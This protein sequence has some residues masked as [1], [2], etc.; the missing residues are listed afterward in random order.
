MQLELLSCTTAQL[1]A[2]PPTGD[3]LKRGP[4]AA[5]HISNGQFGGDFNM[6]LDPLLDTSTG[7]SSLSFSALRQVKLAFFS[8]PHS[9]YSRLDYQNYPPDRFDL[10]PGHNYSEYVTL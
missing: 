2:T 7:T 6:A 5:H 4:S 3:L 9:R 8:P 10:P 1:S